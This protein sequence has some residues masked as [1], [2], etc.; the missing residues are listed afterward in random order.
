MSKAVD[1]KAVEK[2]KKTPPAVKPAKK[3]RSIFKFFKDSKSEF[4][5][6]V[7]PSKKSVIHNTIIVLVM[8]TISSL[9]IWGLDSLFLFIN[10]L[11]MG[12]V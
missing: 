6:V 2:A 5:K 11:V 7:W 3:K 10:K 9:S 8:L 4:N 12:Q 1:K